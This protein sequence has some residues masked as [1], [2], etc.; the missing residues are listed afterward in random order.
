MENPFTLLIADRNRHV[1]E[2]LRREF[3]S[4]GYV[5][6][7][8]KDDRELLLMIEAEANPD[9]LILDLE[10]PYAG[11]PEVLQQL[12]DLKPLLPVVIHTLMTDNADHESVRRA[13][14]F[15]E[16]R[17][18]NIDNLKEVVVSVLRKSYPHRFDADPEISNTNEDQKSAG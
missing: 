3:M 16:K 9:L 6:H 14:A 2:F 10:M 11:G 15:L 5:V 8:A 13:A 18:N 7:L 1:R 4:E 12:L 17:G